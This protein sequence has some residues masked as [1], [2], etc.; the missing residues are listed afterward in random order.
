MQ[1][2]KIQHDEFEYNIL[3]YDTIQCVI[4]QYNIKQFNTIQHN[5]KQYNSIQHNLTHG[6]EKLKKMN[7]LLNFCVYI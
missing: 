6:R 3:R 4:R 7:F 2:I 1:F 5:T